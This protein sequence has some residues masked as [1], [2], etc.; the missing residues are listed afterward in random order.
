MTYVP[1]AAKQ[2]EANTRREELL[3]KLTE[4]IDKLTE[5]A[6]WQKYLDCQARFHHYSFRN[7]LLIVSQHPTATQVASFKKWQ[8]MGR[9]VN[10]GETSLRIL[11]PSLRKVEIEAED[12][13]T[14]EV[15]KVTGF[16]LVPVFDISQTSGVELPEPVKLL[17]GE[18]PQGVFGR[19][20]RFAESIGF[21][22]Q[23]TPEV[24]GH[25]GANGLCEYGPKLIT[26][27]GERSAA[28]QVK[29]LAHEIGHA[30]L[31]GSAESRADRSVVEL[32]AESAAYVVCSQLGM[33]TS[34]YSFGYV[35]VWQG[36][37]A[38]KVR[39]QIKASGGRI[40][41]ASSAIIDGLERAAEKADP[42]ADLDFEAA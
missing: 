28:Q 18:A 12:G 8:E 16:R 27:A 41:Q 11:A 25:P 19:L 37:D 39:D 40:Q 2:A 29:T 23:V 17:D 20:T 9:Q 1:S 5:S 42:E 33:D 35:A 26:V 22:V 36:G 7:C 4:G 10:K 24:E 3:S 38:E 13:K 30:L 32:E 14:D 15:R 31:H 34:G 6:E 21:R